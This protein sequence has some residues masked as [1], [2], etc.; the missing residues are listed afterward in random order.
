MADVSNELS[1]STRASRPAAGFDF[2]RFLGGLP[3]AG[4]NS[5]LI[6]AIVTLL[7]LSAIIW[8]ATRPTYKVLFSGLPEEESVRVVEQLK[9]MNVPHEVVGGGSTIRIPTD[10]VYDIRLEMATLGMPRKNSGTGFEIFDKA[11]LTSM[12]D[13][14]QR[15]NYQRALQGELARTIESITSVRHAR[16]HLVLPKQSAFA[17]DEKAATA[18]VVVELAR[19]LTSTQ[20]DGI[21]HLVA[22]AVQGLDA[23]NV[24]LLDDKGNLIAGGDGAD[25]SGRMAP[26][27]SLEMQRRVEK[28]LEDRAQSMLDRVVGAEHGIVRITAE[29]DLSRVERQ[30]EKFDPDGQVARSEQSINERSQ[31][32]FSA[33]GAPGVAPNDPNA[34]ANNAAGGS[35]QNRNTDRETINYEISK[36]IRK[37]VLPVGTIKRLSIAVMVDGLY[38]A[39][40]KPGEPEQYRERPVEDRNKIQRLIEHAVGFRADRQDMIEV[41]SIPFKSIVPPS[42]VGSLW[43]N[44]EFQLELAKYGSIAFLAALLVFYVLRPLTRRLLTPEKASDDVL[45]DTVLELENRLMSEGVGSM[46]TEKPLRMLIP[47]RSVQLAQQMIN[48]HMDEARN[49]V[50]TW[51]A[52]E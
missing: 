39:P 30:E 23:A 8:F 18:S 52:E 51:M 22:A 1:E 26:D 42:E 29:L 7:V 4:R 15:M 31:G 50:R 34:K 14:M 12:T 2:S 17:A 25:A 13:F 9:K 48:D 5:V 43:T 16:V 32:M 35:N 10:K 41:T 38:D 24:S 49:I 44:T 28:Y 11:G 3:L 27:K 6:A 37:T 20:I 46:P 33:G 19:P 21:V 47:D 40:A 36:E 45:S